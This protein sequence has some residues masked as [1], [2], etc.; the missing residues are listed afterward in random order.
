MDTESSTQS[1]N[2]RPP[3]TEA[4]DLLA[5]ARDFMFMG[6]TPAQ[7]LADEAARVVLDDDGTAE[8]EP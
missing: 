1:G 7:W 2:E 6:M 4:E 8:V 5:A 3:A